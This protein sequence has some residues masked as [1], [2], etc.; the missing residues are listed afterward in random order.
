MKFFTTRT[1]LVGLIATA[2]PTT[3][4]AMPRVQCPGVLPNGAAMSTL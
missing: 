2:A 3:T 1:L 4:M